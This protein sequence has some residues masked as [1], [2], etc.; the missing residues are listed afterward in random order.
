M[1]MVQPG[2]VFT[3]YN[4]VTF[5]CL[6]LCLF[7]AYYGMKQQSGASSARTGEKPIVKRECIYHSRPCILKLP[8]EEVVS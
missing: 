1:S 4:I 2:K 3:S 8:V 6:R 7:F 5:P